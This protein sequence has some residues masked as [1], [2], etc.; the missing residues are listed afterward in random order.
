MAAIG[1]ILPAALPNPL[2][3]EPDVGMPQTPWPWVRTLLH[4]LF[5]QADAESVAMQYDR[6]LDTLGKKLPTVAEH[7]DQARICWHSPPSPAG[8]E[9]QPQQ[10]LN[11]EIRRRTDVADMFPDRGSI[12]RLVGAALAEQHV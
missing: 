9:Q 10:R 1:A 6:M 11:K 3:R 12:V 4:S 8:L 5:D 2:H 7:L